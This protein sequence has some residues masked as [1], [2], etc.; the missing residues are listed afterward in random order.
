M[1][2]TDLLSSGTS[3]VNEDV[4]YKFGNQ[5][6][7]GKVQE[8]NASTG[9]HF[10]LF[11]DGDSGWYSDLRN[12]HKATVGRERIREKRLALR[13]IPDD[14][15]T[16]T[17]R[18]IRRR[19]DGS[20]AA[21]G[22]GVNK[23]TSLSASL[24]RGN[25]VLDAVGKL[26]PKRAKPSAAAQ[27]NKVTKKSAQGGVVKAGKA[28]KAVEAVEAVEAVKAA[29]A[30]KR[31]PS[32]AGREERGK[33]T[34]G[35]KKAATTPATPPARKRS[36]KRSQRRCMQCTRAES[37]DWYGDEISAL[38]CDICQPETQRTSSSWFTGM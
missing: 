9:K 30:V 17:P 19:R 29:K 5:M 14:S 7:D 35:G 37:V 38:K 28:G 18:S 16:G 1:M 32:L 8:W 25:G 20:A 22:D 34:A 10:I 2:A 27:P 33:K 12:N 23:D 26:L 36:S 31:A 11:K 4:W 3:V 21:N 13:S 6:Y 15:C 24:R